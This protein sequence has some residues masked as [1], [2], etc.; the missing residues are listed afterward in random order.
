MQAEFREL[1]QGAPLRQTAVEVVQ[2]LGDGPSR[3]DAGLA[4]ARKVMSP[5]QYVPGY[6][7]AVGHAD[8]LASGTTCVSEGCKLDVRPTLVNF[9]LA[10]YA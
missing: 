4:V 9:I 6:A 5:H 10:M 2:V 7:S 3:E 1:P 8:R